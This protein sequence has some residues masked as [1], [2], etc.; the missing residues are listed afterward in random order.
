MTG[1]ADFYWIWIIAMAGH[2]A[3]GLEPLLAPT[4]Q[5]YRHGAQ[6][7]STADEIAAIQDISWFGIFDALPRSTFAPRI[8]TC[9]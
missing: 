5:E 3:I 9:P 1:D 8:D 6:S 7:Y 4:L 2:V